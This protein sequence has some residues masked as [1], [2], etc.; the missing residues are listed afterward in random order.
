M[1][2]A[3]GGRPG[4]VAT[5][6][7]GLSAAVRLG[8]VLV[9]G[10]AGC[11]GDGPPPAT[12]NAYDAIQ[13]EIFNV[14]CL[15]SGC[16]NITSRAGNL[17]LEAGLSYDNLVDV[18][19]DNVTAQ[20]RGLLRAAPFNPDGSFLLVKL[21][22]PAPGEGEQMPLGMSPL[23]SADITQIRDWILAGAP[24]PATRTARLTASPTPTPSP[25]ALPPAS[26]TPSA[27][28]TVT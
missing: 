26:P 18:V 2:R 21:M 3:P 24:A 12:G 27:S 20:E 22:G 4:V 6:W 1:R 17:I 7:R 19:P 28:P 10:I 15:G 16:H 23:S 5:R 8:L 13:S 14:S 9:V 25:S 11:A